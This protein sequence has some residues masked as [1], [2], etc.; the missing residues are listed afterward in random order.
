MTQCISRVS[1]NSPNSAPAAITTRS[2]VRESILVDTGLIVTVRSVSRADASA[3]MI[4][5]G[6]RPS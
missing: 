1:T 3:D 2:S 4:A 6:R 5:D